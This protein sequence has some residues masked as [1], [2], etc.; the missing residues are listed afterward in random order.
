MSAHILGVEGC[1]NG[2]NQGG[3]ERS[4]AARTKGSSAAA[5]EETAFWR[6][7][8]RIVW[9]ILRAGLIIGICYVILMPLMT[10]ISSSFME[11][12]DMFDVTV[13]WI[14]RHF[15]LETTRLYGKQ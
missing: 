2:S 10:K 1:A 5:R 12:R 3:S 9:R 14:P 4:S 13:R 7:A 6:K 8:G 15:T 11:V